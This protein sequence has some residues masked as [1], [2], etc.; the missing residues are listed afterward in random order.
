MMKRLA[1]VLALVLLSSV[2]RPLEAAGDGSLT[3]LLNELSYW[4][5]VKIAFSHVVTDPVVVRDTSSVG[6]IPTVLA[7]W[8]AGTDLRFKDL[9]GNYYIYKVHKPPGGG[10]RP[11]SGSVKPAAARVP[12]TVAVPVPK[13]E[14]RRS[15]HAPL[16]A[17]RAAMPAPQLHV[18]RICRE[19]PGSPAPLPVPPLS[20]PAAAWAVKTN[21]LYDATSTLNLGFEFGLGRR[22]TLDVSGNYNPWT[23]SQNR[24]M[25]HWLVQPEFRWWSCTRF[26][27]HFVGVHALGGGYNWGGML[28]WG[29]GS[30]KMFGSIDNANIRNHRYE[31]WLAGA[32]VSYGYHWVLGNRW[33]LEAT[34]GVGY[35]YLDYDKY[36][37]AKCGRKLASETKHYFGPTKAGITLIFM[38]K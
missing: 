30:G 29:F 12:Q 3:R 16:L 10:S 19:L 21:L 26:S 23:F 17:S 7:R 8:L 35:A 13:P 9:D 14:V 36:P 1:C 18:P 2:F 27:G 38:I 33:G 37:C 32:G 28:P 31:G 24:K 34:V 11:S 25:K 4:R 22:W 20:L 5:D 6:D 15:R